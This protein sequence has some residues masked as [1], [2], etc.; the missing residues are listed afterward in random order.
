MLFCASL[1]PCEKARPAAVMNWAPRSR[2][3]AA[4]LAARSSVL[5]SR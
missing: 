2:E 5:I 4:G 1:A 3:L